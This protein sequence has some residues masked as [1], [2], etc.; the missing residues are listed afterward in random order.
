[1]RN[2][3]IRIGIMGLG[4]IGR[5]LYHLVLENDDIEIAAVADIGKPEIL[6][7]LL[8]GDAPDGLHCERPQ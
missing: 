4:Q 6:H 5:Q 8:K 1:M 3:K 7:Y 2:G